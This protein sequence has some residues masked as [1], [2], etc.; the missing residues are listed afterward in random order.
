MGVGK[1][2]ERK[3]VRIAEKVDL[4]LLLNFFPPICSLGGQ[5]LFG[6]HE[7]LGDR[8]GRSKNP[9]RLKDEFF[10]GEEESVEE[11]GKSLSIASVRH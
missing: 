4:F 5:K 8:D 11:T 6:N 7:K 3:N 9:G 2:L 1:K 10:L